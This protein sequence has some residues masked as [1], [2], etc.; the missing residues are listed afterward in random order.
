[1]FSYNRFGTIFWTKQIWLLLFVVKYLFFFS[2]SSH[3]F[4]AL[5]STRNSSFLLS[6][7]QA[8]MRLIRTLQ[9]DPIRDGTIDPRYTG[10]QHPDRYILG[11]YKVRQT[12]PAEMRTTVKNHFPK[13]SH[14]KA[15]P[16]WLQA[17]RQI[18]GFLAAFVVSASN[19]ACRNQ[20]LLHAF[21]NIKFGYKYND[22]VAERKYRLQDRIW[23]WMYY[24]TFCKQNFI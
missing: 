1:M 3:P 10:Q 2:S 5:N 8:V 15:H 22:K 17:W 19:L 24:F 9:S 21:E 16:A 11:R 23:N 6:E 4:S 13:K 20:P 12:L 7:Q 18:K 14:F